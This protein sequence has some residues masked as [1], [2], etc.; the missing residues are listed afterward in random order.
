MKAPA[1]IAHFAFDEVVSNTTPDSC[2]TNVAKVDDG[3]TLV[4]GAPSTASASS[5]WS[6]S[7]SLSGG[8]LKRELQ[9]GAPTNHA[10]E[11]NGDTELVCKGVREFRRTDE[12]SFSL[13]LKPAEL[14]ER[15]II[16]HQSRAREDAGS[17]GFELSLDHGKPFFGLIHFWPGNA[18]AVRA[19]NILPTNEW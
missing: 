3:L 4:A 12:F 18:I 10:L 8:T 5:R 19:K 9:P 2:S 11:F 13:W 6:S 17:R 15:A 14:Q 16:F 7:F 1:P